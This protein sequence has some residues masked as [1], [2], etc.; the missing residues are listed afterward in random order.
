MAQHKLSLRWNHVAA[1]LAAA[2]AA[3]ANAFHNMLCM[4][5]IRGK[6]GHRVLENTQQHTGFSRR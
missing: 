3:L 1:K 6:G 4:L 2:R 5:A